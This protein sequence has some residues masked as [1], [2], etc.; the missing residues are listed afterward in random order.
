MLLLFKIRFGN[1]YVLSLQYLSFNIVFFIFS[2]E[3]EILAIPV[4][5]YTVASAIVGRQDLFVKCV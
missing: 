5:V 4:N 1:E 3:S 2:V